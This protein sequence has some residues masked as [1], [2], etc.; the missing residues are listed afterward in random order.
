MDLATLKEKLGEELFG[1]SPQQA[2]AQGICLECKKEALPRCH[3]EAGKREY[4]ISGLCEEC[5]DRT[6][7]GDAA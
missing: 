6:F 5:W 2:Q 1:M 7:S 4:K 3:T